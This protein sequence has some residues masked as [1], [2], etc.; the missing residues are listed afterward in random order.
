M[1]ACSMAN[2]GMVSMYFCCTRFCQA[3]V[4]HTFR[5]STMMWLCPPKPRWG[6]PFCQVIET[7][8]D[9]SWSSTVQSPHKSNS[10]IASHTVA[11]GVICKC[12][13]HQVFS[14]FK[15][16]KCAH[17]MWNHQISD[18]ERIPSYCAGVALSKQP[19][20]FPKTQLFNETGGIGHLPPK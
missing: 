11:L 4:K 17:V 9:E 8:G 1:I 12:S 10:L 18:A 2:S 16:W 19:Q 7:V 5:K 3:F 14:S 20:T 13:A 6:V 15:I